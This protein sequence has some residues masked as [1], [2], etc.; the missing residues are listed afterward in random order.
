MIINIPDNLFEVGDPHEM[1]RIY[2]EVTHALIH[3]AYPI[4]PEMQEDA[5]RR[6]IPGLNWTEGTSR[7]LIMQMAE[8]LEEIA[9]EGTA[10]ILQLARAYRQ[11]LR[12]TIGDLGEAADRRDV[13]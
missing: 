8:E 11:A 3:V 2:E 4:P 9:P 10:N 1:R 7:I 6:L 12:S 13:A 5:S